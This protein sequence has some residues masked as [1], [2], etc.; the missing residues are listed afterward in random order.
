MTARP[1]RRPARL[2]DGL[3]APDEHND[4]GRIACSHV[5]SR[6]DAAVA[7]MDAKWGVDRLPGLLPVD[8]PPHVPPEHR[9]AYRAMPLRY[10]RAVE[11]LMRALAA[12]DPDAV[13]TWTDRAVSVLLAIDRHC[14]LAGVQRPAIVAHH[15]TLDGTRYAIVSDVADAAEAERLFPG[16][17]VLTALQCAIAVERAAAGIGL[18]GECRRV[19]PQADPTHDTAER[20]AATPRGEWDERLGDRIPF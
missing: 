5:V 15:V 13:E 6:F 19:F 10:G 1:T 9:D 11:E 17:R 4:R 3:L 2:A 20:L 12:D 14:D 18:L 16:S 7:A 8:P